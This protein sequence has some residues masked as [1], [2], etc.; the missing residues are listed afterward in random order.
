MKL[1]DIVNSVEE[2]KVEE[3]IEDWVS[4][5]NASYE[6][7]QAIKKLKI[8]KLKYISKHN[9]KTAFRAERSHQI[10]PIDVKNLTGISTNSLFVQNSYSGKLAGFLKETNKELKEIKEKRIKNAYSG[11]KSK[12]K[13]EVYKEYKI[14]KSKAELLEEKNAKDQLELVLSSML[15]STKKILGLI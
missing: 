5:N 11:V 3:K 12:P 15:L 2:K 14:K 1:V 9:T 7:Y 8:E 10:K 13:P 6:G 4:K